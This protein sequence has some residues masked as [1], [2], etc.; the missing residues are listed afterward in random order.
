MSDKRMKAMK[1]MKLRLDWSNQQCKIYKHKYE[2]LRKV[3]CF[4]AVVDPEYL[5]RNPYPTTKDEAS[6]MHELIYFLRN[7]YA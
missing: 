7:V 6:F 3:L 2:A 4:E 5:A 1:V